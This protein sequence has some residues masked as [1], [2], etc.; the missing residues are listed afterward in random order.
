MILTNL[1]ETVFKNLSLKKAGADPVLIK[2]WVK[3]DALITVLGK[4]K[5]WGIILAF[6]TGGS[7]KAG[8]MEGLK[9]VIT[10]PKAYNILP[11]YHNY[12]VDGSFIT[13]GMFIPAYKIV[14]SLIDDRGYCN[15]TEAIAWYNKVRE[16]KGWESKRFNRLPSRILFYYRRSTYSKGR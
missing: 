10:N 8:S 1:E 15:R 7:S 9:T 16:S 12:T 14:Y 6:G 5:K 4:K 2:K 3:G 13:T 11:V